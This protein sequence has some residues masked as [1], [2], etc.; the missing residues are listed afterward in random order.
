MLKKGFQRHTDISAA[1]ISLRPLEFH[2]NTNEHYFFI[3]S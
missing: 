1:S 2:S 3:D